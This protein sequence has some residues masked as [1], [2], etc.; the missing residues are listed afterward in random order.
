MRAPV[1]FPREFSARRLPR[2]RDETYSIVSRIRSSP[3]NSG[4]TG[5]GKGGCSRERRS[6]CKEASVKEAANEGKVSVEN[7]LSETGRGSSYKGKIV[8]EGSKTTRHSKYKGCKRFSKQNLF[9]GRGEIRRK[10]CSRRL[11][12]VE[13]RFIFF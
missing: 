4:C 1:R 3:W 9:W 10:V 6:N 13:S 7:R 5:E 11:E 8:G 2:N 12:K